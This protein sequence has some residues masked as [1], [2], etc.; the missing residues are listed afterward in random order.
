MPFG[1]DSDMNVQATMANKVNAKSGITNSTGSVQA[2]PTYD[3][4]GKMIG[5]SG[6]TTDGRAGFQNLV[7]QIALC[8]VGILLAFNASR[9]APD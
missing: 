4:A 3:G 5:R 9:F 7:A 1:E 2:T 8:K 6:A